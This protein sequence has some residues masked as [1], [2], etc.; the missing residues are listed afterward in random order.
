MQRVNIGLRYVL[1]RAIEYGDPVWQPHHIRHIRSIELIQHKLNR[2]ICN[3]RSTSYTDRSSWYPLT[4]LKTV[5]SFIYICLQVFIWITWHTRQFCYLLLSINCRRIESNYFNH[6][7][8]RTDV[9]KHSLFHRFARTW[10]SLPEH[11]RNEF[12]F[13]FN[14]LKAQL[15]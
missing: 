6:L 4:S 8:A 1:H 13:G 11:V 12:L 15:K 5:V 14:N 3:G 2:I 7:F 10:R 9:F